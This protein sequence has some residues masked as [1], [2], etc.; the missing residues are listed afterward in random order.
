[1]SIIFGKDYSGEK[2]DV[3]CYGLFGTFW[4]ILFHPVTTVGEYF[5]GKRVRYFSPIGMLFLLSALCVLISN[6]DTI[7]GI[8]L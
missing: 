3:P 1:M 6:H 2:G 5:S 7:F 4:R 8:G